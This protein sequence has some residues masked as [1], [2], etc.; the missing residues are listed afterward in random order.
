MVKRAVIIFLIVSTIAFPNIAR[1]DA[2]WH[3]LG[4]LED[5]LSITGTKTYTFQSLSVAGDK[6]MFLDDNYGYSSYYRNETNLTIVGNIFPGLSL[7]STLSNN[8]W[9][10]NERTF[11]LNYDKQDTKAAFGD[12]SASLT[13]NELVS[14]AKQL[15]GVTITQNL[16][17]CRVTAIASKTK[18]STKT[19]T[20]TGNNTPGPY[21]LGVSQ[22]VDGS[23][24]VMIDDQEITRSDGTGLPNYTLDAYSGILTFRD[25][26]IVSST[27]RISVSFELQSIN[28]T[29]GSIYG[30]RS[31]VPVGK[32]TSLGFTYLKQMSDQTVKRNQVQEPFHGN[33]SLG[34][35]YELLYVPELGSVTVQV[36][37]LTQMLNSDYTINYPL[38]YILFNRPILSSSTILVTYT[39]VAD[40]AVSGDRSV[41]GFDAR[42]K[43]SDEVTL[44]SQFAR[45]SNDY[46]G[47]PGGN[48]MTITATAKSGKL[49]VTGNLR[50]ISESFAPIETAG[51][52]RNERGGGLDLKYA[53]TNELSWFSRFDKYVR[54]YYSY[55]NS[56][57]VQNTI[58]AD[59][60]QY[61][62]GFEWK[63]DHLPLIKLSRTTLTNSAENGEDNSQTNDA[64]SLTW[65]WNSITTTGE[66]SRA[67]IS[68]SYLSPTDGSV[69]KTDSSSDTA[70]LGIRY[71]PG[72]RISF[73]ADVADSKIKNSDG[74]DTNAK[75]YQITAGFMATRALNL[76]ASYRLSDSGGHY[77]TAYTDTG[78]TGISTGSGSVIS[79]PSYG[80][81]SATRT[82]SAIWT[83]SSRFT[84]DTNY[85]YTSSAG[86][87]TTNTAITGTDLGF[88]Y[89]PSDILSI[90]A[91]SNKQSGGFSGSTGKM[92]SRIGYLTAAIGPIKKFSLDLN[93]QKM[94]SDTQ[95]SSQNSMVDMKNIGAILRR[96]IGGGRYLFTEYSSS[97]TVGLSSNR[98]NI[99]AF[100]IEYP[101]NRILALKIDWRIIDYADSI[102]IS[103]NY[104][105]NML[106]AQIGARFGQGSIRPAVIKR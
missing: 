14:F 36:D 34:I 105:A 101:L 60:T 73:S 102:N 92:N 100:G 31:D 71:T 6:Q 20:L 7:T 96:D 48:A 97:K 38:H 89:M 46:N 27:S 83:P 42:I 63:P 88:S 79:V 59:Y 29:A 75:N 95:V 67:S 22:I 21:Y 37:G 49:D 50:D 35:P 87:N 18:A 93:Y 76:T 98:K 24:R 11:T 2:F 5:R 86:D 3:R 69:I 19:V 99:I 94:I 13:G 72:G 47:G 65:N 1:A 81:K 40:K 45:S 103:S 84:F 104:H 62:N 85:N 4:R 10:P 54:P 56:S 78:G 91:R 28:S 82:I 80:Q 17:F 32:T 25:G 26:L 33:N 15:K 39:P 57:T 16:G 9:N 58:M 43:V 23:E 51:F 61:S 77:N 8:R 70:R 52:F 55:T 90:H 44:S 64:L 12:I 53:F 106:N 66:F 68:R 74:S 41:M 30:F